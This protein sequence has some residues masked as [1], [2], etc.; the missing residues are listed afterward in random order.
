MNCTYVVFTLKK[1]F[2]YS[3]NIT[4]LKLKKGGEYIDT[5]PYLALINSSLLSFY[6]YQVSSQWGKG[7]EKRAKLRNVDLEKLPV[8]EIKG[9]KKIT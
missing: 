6:F 8:K 5:F 7:A 3:D 4:G 2:V 1:K 9:S